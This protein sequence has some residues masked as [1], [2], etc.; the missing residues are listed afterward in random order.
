MLN[1]KFW[2][3][4]SPN[5]EFITEVNISVLELGLLKILLKITVW[6]L[7]LVTLLLSGTDCAIMLIPPAILEIVN[8]P[9]DNPVKVFID[10]I[11]AWFEETIELTTKM[12][13][14]LKLPACIVA[15]PTVSPTVNKEIVKNPPLEENKEVDIS[16]SFGSWLTDID[17]FDKLS[18][19]VLDNETDTVGLKAIHGE[20]PV[21]PPTQL[22][23]LSM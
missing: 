2:V 15:L 7:P 4:T 10:W 20:L 12:V 8:V 5:S 23:Q 21:L 16:G 1:G 19:L 14:K 11:I 17:K 6:E 3:S 18:Q 13:V 9:N 22:P